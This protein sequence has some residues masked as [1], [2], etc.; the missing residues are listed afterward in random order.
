MGGVKTEDGTWRWQSGDSMEYTNW[1]TDCPDTGKEGWG[2]PQLLT[3]SYPG[4]LN[5]FYWALETI[6]VRGG[7]GV[8]G[9]EQS[10]VICEMNLDK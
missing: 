4:T 1:C 6:G 5:M 7:A 2:Y 8:S 9:S 3:F 10:S